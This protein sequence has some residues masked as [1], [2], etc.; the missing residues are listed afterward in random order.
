[1]AAAAKPQDLLNRV[2]RQLGLHEQALCFADAA[3][4]DILHG[5]HPGLPLE[6][7]GQMGLADISSSETVSV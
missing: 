5:R 2:D 1:M 7:M 4:D 6:Q 3:L